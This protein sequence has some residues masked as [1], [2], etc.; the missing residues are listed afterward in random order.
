[1]RNKAFHYGGSSH[2]S[3]PK[4]IDVGFGKGLKIKIHMMSGNMFV[5]H[6]DVV[7]FNTKH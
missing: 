5:G 2:S 6:I 4:P 1:M 7:V 3:W